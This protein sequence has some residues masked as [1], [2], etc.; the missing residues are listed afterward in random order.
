MYCAI[1][2]T[3]WYQLAKRCI[4][5]LRRPGSISG[6]E[7]LL[8][9]QGPKACAGEWMFKLLDQPSVCLPDSSTCLAAQR[10]AQESWPVHCCDYDKSKAAGFHKHKLS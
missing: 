9:S 10:V 6:M 4:D 3:G 2:N 8:L 7:F 1:N 5:S